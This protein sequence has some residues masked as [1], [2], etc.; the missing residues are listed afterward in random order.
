MTTDELKRA[1]A[2]ARRMQEELQDHQL[3]QPASQPNGA[4]AEAP[5]TSRDMPAV[6]ASA[7][8]ANSEGTVIAVATMGAQQFLEVTTEEQKQSLLRRLMQ[9]TPEQ[10]ESKKRKRHSMCLVGCAAY[11]KVQV[12]WKRSWHQHLRHRLWGRSWHV[13]RNEAGI[14][15]SA[16]EYEAGICSNACGN[17]AGISISEYGNDAGSVK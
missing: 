11:K 9:F 4:S 13:H 7:L 8:V 5:E 17:V 6:A 14:S 16:Y 12:R 1:K 10:I 2:T 15:N 3:P